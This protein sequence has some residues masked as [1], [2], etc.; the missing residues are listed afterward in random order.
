CK[1]GCGIPLCP[2]A[3]YGVA[4]SHERLAN[5]TTPPNA[6]S[7][8]RLSERNPST[9]RNNATEREQIRL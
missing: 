3:C 1:G 2:F 7:Y 8:E 6:S 4:S 9:E 5:G